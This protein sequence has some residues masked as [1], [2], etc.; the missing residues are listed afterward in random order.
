MP[1]GRLS[2]TENNRD[3]LKQYLTEKQK[4]YF[5][6][7]RGRLREVVTMR[8]LTSPARCLQIKIRNRPGTPISTDYCFI[9]DILDFLV[10]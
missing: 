7:A 5:V 9:D 4:G 3:F 6:S 1:G 10:L 2:E 8:E